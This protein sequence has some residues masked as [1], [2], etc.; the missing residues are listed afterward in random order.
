M[1][2]SLIFGVKQIRVPN[3][4]VLGE[5]PQLYETQCRIFT[6]WVTTAT[7]QGC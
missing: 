2:L 7:L 6:L 4:E 5:K 1:G 3:S